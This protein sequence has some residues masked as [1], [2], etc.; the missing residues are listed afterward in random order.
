MNNKE[1]NFWIFSHYN[2][3]EISDE[4]FTFKN[5]SIVPSCFQLQ[6]FLW[7][8][9][10]YA[11]YIY[12][13]VKPTIFS[14]YLSSEA[15]FVSGSIFRLQPLLSSKVVSPDD[16]S[17]RNLIL[18]VKICNLQKFLNFTEAILL[19]STGFKIMT[20]WFNQVFL[21]ALSTWS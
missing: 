4:L 6:L 12:I 8:R 18:L 7:C 2:Q 1:F 10:Q 11:L 21:A 20:Q 19:D 9:Q 17:N 15:T 16:L 5:V 3:M 13:L 14:R